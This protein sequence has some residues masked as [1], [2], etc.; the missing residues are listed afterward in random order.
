[1][2][3]GKK[4]KTYPLTYAPNEDSYQPVHPRSLIS[5]F[6]VHMKKL[7]ILDYP[8]CAQWRF[9]SDCAKAQ[10]DLDLR[11]A[12]MSE[13]RFSDVV[14]HIENI[15]KTCLFKYNEN[16]T[17]K[18]NEN[19]LIKNS[20]IFHISAQNIDCGYSLEPPRR[21]GSNEYQKSM[22]LSITK[23]NNVCPCKPQF[24]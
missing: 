17:T 23:K 1:M 22:F 7:C 13:H 11:W 24:Y 3:E 19:F 10:V 15:T 9:W 12:H 18:K 21:G 16:F 5:V 20:D 6:V 8:K 2:L 14:A 4:T